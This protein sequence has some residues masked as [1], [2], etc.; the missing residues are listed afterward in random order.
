MIGLIYGEL[1][2]INK[3]L[4]LSS[5]IWVESSIASKIEVLAFRYGFVWIYN[6]LRSSIIPFNFFYKLHC[7][8]AFLEIY[9]IGYLNLSSP[10]SRINFR[11]S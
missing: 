1:F 6:F 4:R 7:F 5:K 8:S 9:S 11:V 10:F 3:E 2:I